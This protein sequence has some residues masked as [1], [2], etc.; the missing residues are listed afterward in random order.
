M[1]TPRYERERARFIKFHGEKA[2]LKSADALANG[3]WFSWRK[4]FL[5]AKESGPDAMNILREARDCKGQ[6]KDLRWMLDKLRLQSKG[7][8]EMPIYA[9]SYFL[10]CQ[11]IFCD[12]ERVGLSCHTERLKGGKARV[13]V[14][15][16]GK[17]A[18]KG[19]ELIRVNS[20]F[21]DSIGVAPSWRVKF[22]VKK[23][24]QDV[25]L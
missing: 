25:E 19:S 24:A 22:I 16:H 12:G 6:D 8:F 10:P 13:Y 20:Q 9:Y 18:Y 14:T 4:A 1:T 5:E 2:V 23:M 15:M 7:S 21:F 11:P 17:W 3:W